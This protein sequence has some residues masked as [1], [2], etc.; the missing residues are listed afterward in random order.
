MT[1]SIY[2][3][4]YST[5]MFLHLSNIFFPA[6]LI[7]VWTGVWTGVSTGFDA[8]YLARPLESVNR[9]MSLMLG[10]FSLQ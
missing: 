6:N 1:F 3:H 7:T 2:S 9:F 5:K 8:P 4:P 10:F